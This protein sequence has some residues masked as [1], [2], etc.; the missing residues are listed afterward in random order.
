MKMRSRKKTE[1][2][3]W[4]RRERERKLR[5]QLKEGEVM[6]SREWERERER[7]SRGRERWNSEKWDEDTETKKNK[8]LQ[9]VAIFPP[10]TQRSTTTVYI[11]LSVSIY[12][13]CILSPCFTFSIFVLFLCGYTLLHDRYEHTQARSTEQGFVHD[14]CR[15]GT[16]CTDA[17]LEEN[18]KRI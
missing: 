8:K 6:K 17:K 4:S 5:H 9:P 7:A 3:R 11:F 16:Y 10:V 12:F 1:R 14:N 13:L 2:V 18:K 15:H